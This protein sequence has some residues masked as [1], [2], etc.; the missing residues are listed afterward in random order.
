MQI[1]NKSVVLNSLVGS[2]KVSLGQYDGMGVRVVNGG[3]DEVKEV[4]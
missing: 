3:V 2:L 1:N 4:Q